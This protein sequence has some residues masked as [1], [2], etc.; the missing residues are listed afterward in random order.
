MKAIRR[1]LTVTILS[2][3]VV[4]MACG[5]PSLPQGRGNM[6]SAPFI[7][8][9]EWTASDNPYKDVESQMAK[10]FAEGKSSQAILEQYKKLAE[11]KPKDPVAQFA[12]VCAGRGAAWVISPKSAMPRYLLDTLT[13]A[14]PGNV[15]EYTRY[16]FC[17]TDETNLVLS[18]QNAELIGGRLLAANPKDNWVRL[19][20]INILC[21]TPGG[22]NKA[23]FHALN[24]AKMDPN[25]PKAHSC[26][27]Q[28]YFNQWEEGKQKNMVVGS[29]AILE[30][31]LYLKLA[32]ANDSFRQHA[33]SFIRHIQQ[34]EVR[35]G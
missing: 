19:S 4:N 32:P 1:L 25:N 9:R 28:V 23:L 14:D 8:A 3:T 18:V 20:L 12:Y 29:K 10:D 11:A 34:A 6:T 33:Q 31:Q 30:Y 26:L 7:A 21:A 27:A 35:Q 22:T 15:R 24:W 5:E 2:A 17:L 13:K 16:R